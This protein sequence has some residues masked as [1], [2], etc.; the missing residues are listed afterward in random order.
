MTDKVAYTITVEGTWTIIRFPTSDIDDSIVRNSAISFSRG[1][2]DIFI[3]RTPSVI[4]KLNYTLDQNNIYD[5]I[6]S[7]LDNLITSISIEDGNLST[8]NPRYDAFARLRVAQPQTLFNSKLI[9]GDKNPLLWDEAIISGSGITSS[10]PTFAQPYSDITSTINTACVFRRQ[11]K[12]YFNYQPGK[13]QLI[14]LTGV[15]LVSGGGEGVKNRIGYFDDDDGLYFEYDN[16]TVYVV[17]RSNISGT[18][19]E[20]RIPQ[21][22]WNIDKLDGTGKSNITLDITKSQIFVID[23]QWLSIGRVRYGFEIDGSLYY[24]HQQNCANSQS[25]PYMSNPN[26]PIRA[27]MITTAASPATTMRVICSAVISEGGIEPPNISFG[28]E[29]DI[30]NAN[31]ITTRYTLVAIR[32]KPDFNGAQIDIQNV[33][34]LSLTADSFIWSI[35][36]NPTLNS[37]LT[38][39][40]LA[41][42]AVEYALGDSGNPS[43][44]SLTTDGTI[45]SSGFGTGNSSVALAIKGTLKLGSFIDGTKDIIVLAV[46][47]ISSN[48]DIKGILNIEELFT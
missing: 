34:I 47:P 23:F 45:I 11:T 43:S 38:F 19:T 28:I 33:D 18:P 17:V 35:H 7:Y 26:L 42:S 46:K 4:L 32:L 5:S 6:N 40:P 1:K 9:N 29:S 21:Q 39:T 41:N 13:S 44:T 22:N 36:L 31:S 8:A 15:L 37:P 10:T 16:D 2:S 48:A 3:L 12:R 24:A 25:L 20:T 30:I 27:E 14:L